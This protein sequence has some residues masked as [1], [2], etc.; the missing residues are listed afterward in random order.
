MYRK[1]HDVGLQIAYNDEKD[2]SVK[3]ATQKMCVI[4]VIS[5]TD[6]VQTFYFLMEDFHKTFCQ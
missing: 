5:L 4:A 2:R 1:I 3:I 6:V